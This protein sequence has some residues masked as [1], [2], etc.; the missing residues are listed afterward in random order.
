[1]GSIDGYVFT[2]HVLMTEIF[3]VSNKLIHPVGRTMHRPP[4]RQCQF[5][6]RRV[7]DE[8]IKVCIQLDEC[9]IYITG[10]R[11][12]RLIYC[13]HIL[14]EYFHSVNWYA[15][16]SFLLKKHVPHV[17]HWYDITPSC[18]AL[19]TSSMCLQASFLLH[20]TQSYFPLSSWRASCLATP[21]FGVYSFRR[22]YKSVCPSWTTSLWRCKAK[23]TY[24]DECMISYIYYMQT[25]HQYAD[26]NVS[27][28]F[29]N[30]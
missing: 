10:I 16:L 4:H 18:I 14:F 30:P 27:L 9:S 1:M 23:I 21:C 26:G 11:L 17:P 24:I 3:P 8:A 15:L 29:T 25:F 28:S 19:C 7:R 2:T 20:W 12:K 6:N 5:Y 13:V 22:S